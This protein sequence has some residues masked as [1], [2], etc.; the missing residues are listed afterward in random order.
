MSGLPGGKSK[1]QR[2]LGV[3]H[4]AV[5]LMQGDFFS[6]LANLSAVGTATSARR[7]MKDAV[8]QYDQP[9]MSAE[10]R[11]VAA[12]DRESA[13]EL[14]RAALHRAVTASS[15]REKTAFG[16]SANQSPEALRDL[17][18]RC[19]DQR[20]FRQLPEDAQ[21]YVQALFASV[22]HLVHDFY[23]ENADARNAILG[24]AV[25]ALQDAAQD[26][27]RALAEMRALL[28]EAAAS[29]HRMPAQPPN[30][31]AEEVLALGLVLADPQ[32]GGRG[33]W[34]YPLHHD[35]VVRGLSDAQATVALTGLVGK[36]L[37]TLQNAPTRDSRTGEPSTAPAYVVTSAGVGLA[38]AMGEVLSRRHSYRYTLRFDADDVAA[39]RLL[40]Q[41]KA[42]PHVQR[43][44][45]YYAEED[46][47]G[48]FRL[49]LFT[50]EPFAQAVLTEA[51]RG[52][53]VTL[54]EIEPD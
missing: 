34:M 32:A 9:G 47:A 16:A 21:E 4:A 30:L 14:V 11:E 43:Q 22:A 15:S 53:G 24:D 23:R 27:A 17:L 31:S 12:A 45:R 52:Q 54:R 40:T 49:Y 36:G 2:S 5:N 48:S 13:E 50:Y 39:E 25:A 26:H 28:A 41:L 19:A 51:A 37:V 3:A 1:A 29:P 20:M 8:K 35:L 46:R 44:T 7:F 6:A 10:F 33:A 18:I 38:A 42:M